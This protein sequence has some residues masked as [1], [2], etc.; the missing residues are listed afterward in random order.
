MKQKLKEWCHGHLLEAPETAKALQARFGA[1]EKILDETEV[2]LYIA[3]RRLDFKKSPKLESRV[4][5]LLEAL[6][7][8]Y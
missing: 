3:I 8:S 5:A 6:K 4:T 1:L 7:K 2:V